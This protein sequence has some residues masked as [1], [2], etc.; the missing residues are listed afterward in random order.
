[1]PEYKLG[2][3]SSTSGN[4][5]GKEVRRS[6]A[7]IIS[8]KNANHQTRPLQRSPPLFP[9][10]SQGVSESPSTVSSS[11]RPSLEARGFACAGGVA[12]CGWTWLGADCI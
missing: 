8:S 4:A 10:A 11:L 7:V 6:V 12:G 3:A 2:A 5:S 1:M 9:G